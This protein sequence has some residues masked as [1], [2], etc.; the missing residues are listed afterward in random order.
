MLGVFQTSS[1]ASDACSTPM[2]RCLF[3]LKVLGSQQLRKSMATRSSEKIYAEGY[4]LLPFTPDLVEYHLHPCFIRHIDYTIDSA[5]P[6]F[7]LLWV[8]SKKA[9]PPRARTGSSFRAARCQCSKSGRNVAVFIDGTSNQFSAKNTNIVELYSMVLR[10]V[11][12]QATYYNSGIG[13]F[14][15]PSWRSPKYLKQRLYH[16]IDTAIAWNFERIVLSAYHWLVENYQPGDCIYLFGFSRGAYQVRVIAGM[17]EKVG[18][19]H[20]GNNDQIP[21]AFELYSATMDKSSRSTFK[22]AEELCQRFKKTLSQQSVKVHFVGVWDT[23]VWFV[24]SHSDIGGGNVINKN[25]DNFGP[26]LRWMMSEARQ[27]GLLID[28]HQGKWSP[29]EPKQSLSGVWRVLELLPF[30]HLTYKTSVATATR[31]H[32]GSPRVIRPGQRIHQ[33]VLVEMASTNGYV[34]HARL[35]GSVAL[36]YDALIHNKD[37]LEEDPF[38]SPSTILTKLKYEGI[39][40]LDEFDASILAFLTSSKSGLE[41][42]ASYPDASNILI[43]ALNA[44]PCMDPARQERIRE[45]LMKASFTGRSPRQILETFQRLG[46]TRSATKCEWISRHGHVILDGPYTWHNSQIR[47]VAFASDGTVLSGSRDKVVG[48]GKDILLRSVYSLAFSADGSHFAT[49]MDDGSVQVWDV[50]IGKAVATLEGHAGRVLSLAFSR[51]GRKIA[52]GSEDHS[53][54]VGEAATGKNVISWMEGHKWIISLAFSPDG[55]RLVSGSRKSTVWLWDA[56][57]GEQIRGLRGHDKPVVSVAFSADGTR[58]SSGGEDM[59]I[60][61]W[62]VESGEALLTLSGHTGFIN[63]V[64]FSPD[65]KLV[66]SCARDKTVFVWATLSGDLLAVYNV[67]DSVDRVAVSPDSTRII[68]GSSCGEIHVWDADLLL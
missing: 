5:P 23:E 8:T 14:A 7:D 21:F 11:M 24:G 37:I 63:C 58:I 62:D 52:S 12:F 65:C 13:T 22:D 60:F 38:A 55:Q 46:E 18:L 64:A 57:A 19:L 40:E 15:R 2:S 48:S 59:K 26:A 4:V 53:I 9:I 10:D 1:Y 51:D 66:V 49:G 39:S 43:A 36:E 27:N 45:L 54:R 42:I 25:L 17:I 61:V 41:A 50:A 33:S 56:E 28:T 20:K 29:L 6:S 3:A 44:P 47:D 67:G 30:R 16:L 31:P 32:L 35:P 68:S 34:P